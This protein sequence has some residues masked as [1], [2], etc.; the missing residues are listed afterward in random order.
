[1]DNYL[2]DWGVSGLNVYVSSE[3]Q[4]EQL[5]SEYSEFVDLGPVLET[6]QEYP[7][8]I[9]GR[10]SERGV[11]H[12]YGVFSDSVDY[13]QEFDEFYGQFSEALAEFNEE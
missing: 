11:F 12:I 5:K 13:D 10:F 8:V 4:I 9:E 6:S 2:S 7:L 3:Q 1:M